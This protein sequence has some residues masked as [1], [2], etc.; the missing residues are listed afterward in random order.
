MKDNVLPVAILTSDWHMMPNA[1]KW[2]PTLCGDAECSLRQIADESRR[3]TIPILAAG[4]LFNVKM[5]DVAT[6]LSTYRLLR[7]TPAGCCFTQGNHERTR[8]PWMQ[9]VAPEWAHASTH[10]VTLEP[11]LY[12]ACNLQYEE[13]AALTLPPIF[14]NPKKAWNIFGIDYTDYL[15]SLQSQLDALEADLVEQDLEDTPDTVNVL[16]L[17]QT[18]SPLCAISQ[19]ELTDRMIPDC[20][21]LVIVGHWHKASMFNLFSKS[22]RSIPCL[23]PGSLHMWS[24]SEEPKKYR[25]VLFNDGSIRSTPLQTRRMITM[26]ISGLTD[27]EIKGVGNAVLASI[28]KPDTRPEAIRAPIVYAMR[29]NETSPAAESILEQLFGDKAHL[30]MKPLVDNSSEHV[31]TAV[32]EDID[33]H[34]YADGGF[35]YAKEVF[36]NHEKDAVVRH[37]VESMLEN[38]PSFDLY[39]TLKNKFLSS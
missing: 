17:H 32:M 26:A 4:D 38:D 2:R 5:P 13:N 30:F 1:W 25:H 31:D 23:S 15:D 12:T 6:L 22:G 27:T 39:Q 20:F 35:Q 3:T 9:L 21:D 10:P 29:D 36:Y 37:L 7:N 34:K 19:Y 18:A 24:I 16:M 11:E 8:V 28:N 14:D 33:L